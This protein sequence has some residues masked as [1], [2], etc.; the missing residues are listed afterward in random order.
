MTPEVEDA[1]FE[2]LAGVAI[3]LTPLVAHFIAQFAITIPGLIE[4]SWAVDWIFLAIA[5]SATSVVSV[6]TKYRRGAPEVVRGRASPALIAVTIL[7]LVASSVLYSVVATGRANGS[8][9][10]LA[11]GI[12]IGAAIVSLYFEL[13]LAARL[14]QARGPG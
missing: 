2:W 11:A 3:G 14:A 9:V 4:G 10:F 8:S 1:L 12:F 6:V 5:T 7:F 13:T